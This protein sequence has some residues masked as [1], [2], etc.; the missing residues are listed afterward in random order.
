MSSGPKTSSVYV[1]FLQNGRP[2]P[3]PCSNTRLSL[4]LRRGINTVCFDVTP[5]TLLR[6]GL[7]FE[8]KCCLKFQGRISRQHSFPNV[9]KYLTSYMRSHTGIKSWIIC[10]IKDSEI[11]NNHLSNWI[12]SIKDGTYFSRS[13]KKVSWEESKQIKVDNEIN[14]TKLWE[15]P[16]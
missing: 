11:N 12:Q 7:L 2:N 3:T 5:C 13:M 6:I 4:L 8:Y 1:L 16:I 14:E 15:T 10:A 9:I